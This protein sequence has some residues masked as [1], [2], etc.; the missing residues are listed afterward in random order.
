MG[1]HG[2][3]AAFTVDAG[4]KAF[5]ASAFMLFEAQRRAGGTRASASPSMRLL[6]CMSTPESAEKLKS[7]CY[8]REK[9]DKGLIIPI[10]TCSPRPGNECCTDQEH[11]FKDYEAAVQ[12]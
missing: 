1:A 8:D 7:R 4:Y 5:A 6:C 11:D 10:P 2:L 12:Y 9:C 3:S